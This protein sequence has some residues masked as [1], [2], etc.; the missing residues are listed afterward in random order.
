M[1][2]HG[3]NTP[4]WPMLPEEISSVDNLLS[5]QEQVDHIGVTP[6]ENQFSG[7]PSLEN[8]SHSPLFSLDSHH[9]DDQYT[10]A[11][12]SSCGSSSGPGG[13]GPSS[14]SG[15]ILDI[16]GSRTVTVRRNKPIPRKGHTK[17]RRGCYTCKRRKVK[18]SEK[19]PECDNCTRIGLVCEYPEP[20]NPSALSRLVTRSGP[21]GGPRVPQR[22]GDDPSTAVRMVLLTTPPSPTASPSLMTPTFTME[23]LRFFHHFLVAA[24][25]P[26]PVQ[27]DSVWNNVAALS[28]GVSLFSGSHHTVCVCLTSIEI[29]VLIPNPRHAR[30]SRLSPLPPICQ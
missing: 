25:P 22:H 20:P 1:T 7:D 17:S 6:F 2:G 28:H 3:N 11:P 15:S 9:H 23:D 26:L 30:P 14:G 5:M 27:A 16:P 4:E 10:R 24:H 19:L 8:L 12:E 29:I 13:R 18:C 21:G